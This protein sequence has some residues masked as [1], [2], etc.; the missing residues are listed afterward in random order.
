MTMDQ[1]PY[2]YPEKSLQLAA[3]AWIA[4]NWVYHEL[5]SDAEA[6]GDRMD[7]VGLISGKPTAIEVK[8]KIHS[9]LVR[10]KHRQSG[11]LESK[12]SSTLLGFYSGQAGAQLGLIRRRWDGKT[13]L[14]I[15]ILAG[16]YTKPGFAELLAMLAT[17]SKEWR[18][19]YLVLLWTGQKVEIL[20][21]ERS[22]TAPNS[23]DWQS[24]SIPYLIGKQTRAKTTLCDLCKLADVH[25]VRSIFEKCLRLAHEHRLSVITRATGV[26]LKLPSE[27]GGKSVLALYLSASN[28]GD[29]I[30]VGIDADSLKIS[31]DKLPG[32]FAPR[33][34]FMNTNRF[35]KANEDFRALIECFL[36]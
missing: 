33:A 24:I 19:N 21:E 16:G 34:G 36:I 35:I 1:N 3:I 8:T 23:G 11:S 5:A 25:G 20:F 31:L 26:T 18:F 27:L 6:T 30:N 17:R 15:G 13:P 22:I 29:G 32:I 2:A 10:H 14:L 12:I 7:S 9:G 4:K 28:E